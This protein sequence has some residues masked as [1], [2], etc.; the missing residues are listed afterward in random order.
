MPGHTWLY[1]WNSHIWALIICLARG[2]VGPIVGCTLQTCCQALAAHCM[3]HTPSKR[4]DKSRLEFIFLYQTMDYSNKTQNSSDLKF[5]Q[6]L[7]IG[8][9]AS[10]FPLFFGYRSLCSTSMWVASAWPRKTIENLIVKQ[11]SALFIPLKDEKKIK[12]FGC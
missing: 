11:N 12:I 7:I 4:M 3:S 2:G 10:S 1:V 8:E 9:R 6:L 5:S